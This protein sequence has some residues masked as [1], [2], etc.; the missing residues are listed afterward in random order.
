[1]K[2]NR[3]FALCFAALAS[4]TTFA[5]K[6]DVTVLASSNRPYYTPVKDA[7]IDIDKDTQKKTVIMED[8]ENWNDTLSILWAKNVPE[9]TNSSEKIPNFN[10]KSF[11]GLCPLTWELTE[12][13]N[14][15]VLHCYMKTSADIVK[16]IWLASEETGIV[17]METGTNYRAQ[18]SVP[19]CM[20]KYF[21]VRTEEDKVLDFQIYFPKLPS[22]VTR[23][24]VYG[25]P[26]WLMRGKVIN[27]S[28]TKTGYTAYDQ[29]P[30]FKIPKLVS[31]EKDYDKD[32]HQSW[33]IYT[34]PHLI[35]P[36]PEG[37]MA[38]WRTP[39]ATYLAVA[40][41]QNW[42]RE[43][44][45]IHPSTILGD[46]SG[47][48][49]KLK[50]VKGLPSNGHIFWM[51]GYSGDF[52]VFLYVFEPIPLDLKTI[53]FLEPDSEPFSMWGANWKGDSKFGLS[54]DEL[55]SNQKLFEYN[56]RRIVK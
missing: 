51:E 50:E 55:I 32:K 9:I 25:I 37:T 42:M 17:D 49:Y 40:H 13:G 12:E 26:T 41:E 18:R 10:T 56:K 35:K 45:G 31:K 4:I 2:T 44:F 48:Q 3:T 27:I 7:Y 21:S 54:I 16:N 36:V 34:E 28:R 20:G 30:D 38:I 24:S 19:D 52:I 5:Q 11:E 14:N 47:N 15:T 6:S 39:E 29:V 1:M 53:S 22:K 46:D 23:I 33:E 43:Y 8:N